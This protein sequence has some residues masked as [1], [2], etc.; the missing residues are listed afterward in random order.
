MFHRTVSQSRLWRLL[1]EVDCWSACAV[2]SGSD[3]HMQIQAIIGDDVYDHGE[4]LA[5]N[6]PDLELGHKFC[7]RV[8]V[9]GCDYKS[10]VV[11][12]DP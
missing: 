10:L 4:K 9:P 1:P 2:L 7:E 5:N 3:Q 6:Y 11:L 12:T 8:R